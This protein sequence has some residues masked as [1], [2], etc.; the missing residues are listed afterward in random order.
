M[1]NHADV[2]SQPEDLKV[3]VEDRLVHLRRGKVK[4]PTGLLLS[5]AYLFYLTP[6]LRSPFKPANLF[7]TADRR[8]S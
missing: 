5:G 1:D 3:D 6:S 2:F 8:T 7:L 4:V